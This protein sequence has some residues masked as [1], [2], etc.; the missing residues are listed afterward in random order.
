VSA[1]PLS[2]F[3][4]V[5]DASGGCIE[6]ATV[7]VIGGQRIGTVVPQ[8]TPCSVWDYGNGFVLTGLA[9]GVAMTLRGSAPDHVSKDVT[10]YPQTGTFTALAIVL[11]RKQ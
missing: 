1:G 4:F 6:G 9:P 11:S 10:S 3:G 2:L 5:V 8:V 7:E